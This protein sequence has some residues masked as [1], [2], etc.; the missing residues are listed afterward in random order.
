[1]SL[2]MDCPRCWGKVKDCARC[3][4][5][6]KAP[7]RLLSPHFRLSELLDSPT[8]RAKGLANDPTPEIEANL[9][10]LC[11]D[12]LEPIRAK[13]G[14]LVLNSGYRSDAVNSAVGGSKTSAH[15]FGLAADLKPPNGCKALMDVIIQS[16]V[17]LDQLIYEHTWVHVGL[18]H[19]ATGKQRGDRLTMNVVNGKTT[20]V[21]YV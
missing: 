17:H 1:M 16:G 6:G 20:Y 2:E 8:A 14:P 10:K 13:V 15:S 4:G 19:P 5:K 21:P 9:E 12:A 7:D 11:R 3:H 18:L